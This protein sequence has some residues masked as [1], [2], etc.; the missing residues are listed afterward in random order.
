[1]KT[2]KEFPAT[3]SMSTEWFIADEE[4]N[5][6]LISFDENGPIPKSIPDESNSYLMTAEEDFGEKDKDSIEYLELTDDQIEELMSDA[7]PPDKINIEKP[8]SYFVQ[9]DESYKKEF[10][11]V[12]IDEIDFCLSHKHGIYFVWCIYDEDKPEFYRNR[13]KDTFLRTV[14]RAVHL[15]PE[16]YTEDYFSGTNSKWPLPFY[17]YKQPYCSESEPIKRTNV[18]KHPFKEEQISEKQRK[19]LVRLPFKFSECAEFKIDDFIDDCRG[20]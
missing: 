17:C 12:F 7:V 14:K 8:Y 6:A 2:N 19:K 11:D 13:E 3:H 15:Y 5:I 10:F 16:E 18:P 9:L 1:M 4:G 20:Y